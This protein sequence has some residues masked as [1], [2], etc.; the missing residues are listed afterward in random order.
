MSCLNNAGYIRLF[1][2]VRFLPLYKHKNICGLSSSSGALDATL[3]SIRRP[4]GREEDKGYFSGK[5]GN[6]G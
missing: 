6:M 3:I 1:T 4:S 2:Y 5:H